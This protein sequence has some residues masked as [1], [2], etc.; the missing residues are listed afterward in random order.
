MRQL[1]VAVALVFRDGRLFLQRR[2]PQAKAFPGCWELPG[3][4]LEPGET[5]ER[6]LYRELEEELRWT[7]AEAV[8]IEPV[9]YVYPDRNVKLHPFRCSGPGPLHSP[10]A[11]GWFFPAEARRL[12]VPG[13]T[14]VLLDALGG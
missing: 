14:R 7:P 3:G 11:W 4:K 8:P 6:A 5:A 12:R 9:S 1:D 2:D 13:A 10:L